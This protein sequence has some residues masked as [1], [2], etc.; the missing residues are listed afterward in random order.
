MLLAILL[1]LMPPVL[2]QI[3]DAFSGNSL[4]KEIDDRYDKINEKHSGIIELY[5]EYESLRQTCIDEPSGCNQDRLDDID[6][7]IEL[8][9]LDIQL[10]E[11]EID[12]LRWKSVY[13][14]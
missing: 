3:Y 14:R 7:E 6:K 4:E 2:S 11:D 13:N 1:I 9:K 5:S 10:L 12:H 8:L